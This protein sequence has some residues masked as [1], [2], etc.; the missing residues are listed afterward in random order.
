MFQLEV[1]IATHIQKLVGIKESVLPEDVSDCPVCWAS[2]LGHL[3]TSGVV[4]GVEGSEEVRDQSLNLEPGVMSP[5]LQ[6][7]PRSWPGLS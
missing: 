6:Q 1:G 5:W 4:T 7:C 3:S 2:P